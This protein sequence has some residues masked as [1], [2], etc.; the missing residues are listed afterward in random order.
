[1]HLLGNTFSCFWTTL[2]LNAQRNK[3]YQ[4]LA[5]QILASRIN[6]LLFFSFNGIG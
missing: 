1:M 4:V 3:I 5:T 6:S 2:D